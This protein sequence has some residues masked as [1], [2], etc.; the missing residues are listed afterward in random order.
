[1]SLYCAAQYLLSIVIVTVL[2]KP[3]G[4]YV[5]RVFTGKR[6][7]LDRFC[8]P[9][10]KVLYRITAVDPT[11]EMTFLQYATCFVLFG[12]CGTLLLL[13]RGSRVGSAPNRP[14]NCQVSPC[15]FDRLNSARLPGRPRELP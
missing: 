3:L 15:S 10:E 1:V 8:L 13:A 9:V 14:R 2:V 7:A 5:E 12:L 6:T 4:A 11:V